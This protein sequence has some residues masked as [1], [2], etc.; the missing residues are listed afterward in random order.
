MNG[1]RGGR[2]SVP[3]L[4]PTGPQE[5]GRLEQTDVEAGCFSGWGSGGGGQAGGGTPG[6]DAEAFLAGAPFTQDSHLLGDALSL[7]LPPRPNCC[8]ILSPR[9]QR[10]R[11]QQALAW[12]VKAWEE[13]TL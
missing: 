10:P 7:P 4:Y 1:V 12:T 13:S 5:P 9:P 11:L 2:A 8:G 6:G 3:G